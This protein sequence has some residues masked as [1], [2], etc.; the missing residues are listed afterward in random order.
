MLTDFEI[1]GVR[2]DTELLV[3]SVGAS[4][5][6]VGRFPALNLISTAEGVPVGDFEEFIYDRVS[7][8]RRE[9]FRNL[10][11][12]TPHSHSDPVDYEPN[13][14]PKTNSNAGWY[15][16]IPI[17]TIEEHVAY[18]IT[19]NLPLGGYFFKVDMALT[20]QSSLG[21]DVFLSQCTSIVILTSIDSPSPLANIDVI[22]ARISIVNQYAD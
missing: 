2:A 19:N 9:Y 20:Y 11:R 4:I 12:F 7:S 8:E 13:V 1:A 5:E 6:N 3:I 17:H 14:F 18:R 22:P 10:L 21:P 15:I 16:K